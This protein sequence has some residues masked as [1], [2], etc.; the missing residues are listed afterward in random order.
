MTDV[1]LINGTQARHYLGMEPLIDVILR[2]I[3]SAEH[4]EVKRII[5]HE[6]IEYN[7]DLFN[8]AV[9]YADILI[10]MVHDI[11]RYVSREENTGIDLL[12]TPARE[13][14][15]HEASDVLRGLKGRKEP[16]MAADSSFRK[17]RENMRGAESAMKRFAS[18]PAVQKVITGKIM[19]IDTSTPLKSY[20]YT[21]LQQ[22]LISTGQSFL[23]SNEVS[24]LAVR[25]EQSAIDQLEAPL[26]SGSEIDAQA[27]QLHACDIPP[28]VQRIHALLRLEAR[29]LR[30][31]IDKLQGFL[32][33]STKL[34]HLA[35]SIVQQLDGANRSATVADLKHFSTAIGSMVDSV[36][37]STLPAIPGTTRPVTPPLKPFG[38]RPSTGYQRPNA[39]AALGAIL[40]QHG[41]LSTPAAGA[42][43]LPSRLNQLK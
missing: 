25:N 22:E 2:R 3:P 30:T 42:K 26:L 1:P 24:D 14:L 18:S 8:E 28:A 29:E 17:P 9:T 7:A 19:H 38:A 36:S 32:A 5:G 16:S 27:F 43:G 35:R 40:M 11:N 34:H 20:A 31:K 10:E 41:Q 23:P 37:S 39:R 12:Y 33:S 15:E 21:I 13:F 6:I 4:A